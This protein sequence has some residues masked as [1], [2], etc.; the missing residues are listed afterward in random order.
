[1]SKKTAPIYLWKLVYGNPD[2][3]HSYWVDRISGRI[4]IKD[5]S[6]DYPDKTDDGVLWLDRDRPLVYD[7]NPHGSAYVGIPLLT[8]WGEENSS[9]TSLSKAIR[10][11]ERFHMNIV[12]EDAFL[13]DTS[14][15]MIDAKRDG[16]NLVISFF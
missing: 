13:S 5:E 1:M 15:S 12:V 16:K 10:I 9:V 14:N 7:P 6:G 11:A 4:A 8:T 2:K 3:D